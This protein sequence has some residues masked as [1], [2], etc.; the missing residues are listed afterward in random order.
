LYVCSTGN[1]VQDHFT[2]SKQNL[3]ALCTN[4]SR[5][6]SATGE[7]DLVSGAT[8]WGVLILTQSRTRFRSIHGTIG[9]GLVQNISP[10][11]DRK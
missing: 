5:G 3:F 10:I 4:A 8:A 7:I 2:V 9:L 1:T 6:L 11:Q